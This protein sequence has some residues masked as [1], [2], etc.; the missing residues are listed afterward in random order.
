LF[1]AEYPAATFMNSRRMEARSTFASGRIILMDWPFN[2]TGD[3]FEADDFNGNIYEIHN[4]RRAKHL[5]L[6][7]E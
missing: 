4:E 3:L 6:R 2:S 7:V 5:C 1:V